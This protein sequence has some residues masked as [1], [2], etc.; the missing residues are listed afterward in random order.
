MNLYEL[1]SAFF[2]PFFLQGFSG[3][4][5]LV[6]HT[7]ESHKSYESC[8]IM[9]CHVMSCSVLKQVGSCVSIINYYKH[10][11]T[12]RNIHALWRCWCRYR[13]LMFVCLFVCAH[14]QFRKVGFKIGDFV[15]THTFTSHPKQ[16]ASQSVH[17]VQCCHFI[18]FYYILLMFVLFV[19]V[20][21]C[22]FLPVFLPVCTKFM[23][24]A[25]KTNKNHVMSDKNPTRQ[26]KVTKY[27]GP[28]VSHSKASQEGGERWTLLRNRKEKVW[29]RMLLTCSDIRMSELES[30]KI[31]ESMKRTS[32]QI[33][34]NLHLI[35]PC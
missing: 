30:C 27:R 11:M 10:C 7:N 18:S 28:L 6:H 15:P 2:G 23:E 24:G 20:V 25:T 29:R 19:H 8:D 22:F 13:L 5:H 3:L 4:C 35:M 32:M 34:A 33:Y 1:P 31:N 9:R 14:R 17:L 21:V 26:A 12:L 16:A